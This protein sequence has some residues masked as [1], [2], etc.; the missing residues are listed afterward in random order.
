M[1][2]GCSAYFDCSRLWQR[3]NL[4]APQQFHAATSGWAMLTS[5]TVQLLTFGEVFDT[6]RKPGS[7]DEEYPLRRRLFRESVELLGRLHLSAALIAGF[8]KG[9]E[10]RK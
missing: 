6:G 7:P 9:W 4:E 3:P 8:C 5:G 2:V 1:G 10:G